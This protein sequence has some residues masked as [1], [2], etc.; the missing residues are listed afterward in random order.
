M[1]N[2]V[3]FT[4]EGNKNC[5]INCKLEALAKVIQVWRCT[6][7]INKSWVKNEIYEFTG[8]SSL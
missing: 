8:Q 2:I 7:M 5:G 4:S 6:V 1:Y 3:L